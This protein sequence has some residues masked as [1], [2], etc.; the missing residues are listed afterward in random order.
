MVAPTTL[1]DLVRALVSSPMS[2]MV[3]SS[4]RWEGLEAVDLRDGPGDDDRH[5]VGHVVQFQRL[6]NGLLQHLGVQPHHVGVIKFLSLLGSL[7]LP[8]DS[9]L[10]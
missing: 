5:G 4:F 3:Y 7:L 2:Y 10:I 8:W 9:F 1:A 6:S